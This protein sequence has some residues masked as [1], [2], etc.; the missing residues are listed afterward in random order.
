MNEIVEGF[1]EAIR[2]IVTLDPEV[3]EITVRSLVIS[4]IATVLSAAVSIPL[5][6]LL[7][8]REFPGKGAVIGVIQTLYSLPTVIAG[9]F[10]FLLLSNAGPF[11]FL[12]LLFTPAGMVIA[13][14]VLILPITTGLTIAALSGI[15]REV[16]DTLL[17]LG[18]TEYQSILAILGEARFAICSALLLGFGR[19]ISEVGAAMIVGGNIRGQ[20][21]I[22]TTAISLETSIGNFSLSIAL[23]IIL[24]LLALGVNLSLALLGRWHH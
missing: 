11:G 5:G 10:I 7:Y 23:G 8:L 12:R 21:R 14:T 13:Q 15:G 4:L 6:S 3:L 17:S 19:A 1:I 24:L 18:A 20:T 9:L 2:L 16:R 22:L